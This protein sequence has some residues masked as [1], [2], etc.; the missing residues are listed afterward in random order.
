[1]FVCM[2]VCKTWPIDNKYSVNKINK[3][4]LSSS[5]IFASDYN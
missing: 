2:Y 4:S 5:L 3:T 1:M